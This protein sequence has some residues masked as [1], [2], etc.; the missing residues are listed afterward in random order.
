MAKKKKVV[1]HKPLMNFRSRMCTNPELSDKFSDEVLRITGLDVN[2]EG[3]I[4][5]SEEDPFEPDYIFIKGKML[6]RT[7]QGLLFAK[8]IIFDPY[9]NPMIMEELFKQY[10]QKY[11]PE[12]SSTQIMITEKNT[13]GKGRG[14]LDG[15]MSI[16]YS[17]GAKI[18]TNNHIKD[19]TKILE[20]FMRLEAMTDD[21]VN[22]LLKPFD[23]YER[24]QFREDLEKLNSK[25]R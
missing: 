25:K 13:E 16:I 9:N 15:Y 17:N 21:L 22:D 24:T 4:V 20:A 1:E 7:N 18:I 10:L 5:D 8:D 3:Y 6:R 2:D 23:E 12:I 14:D 19:S 11:H